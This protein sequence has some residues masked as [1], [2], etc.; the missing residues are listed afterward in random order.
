MIVDGEEREYQSG[1]LAAFL[2]PKELLPIIEERG[3]ACED[4]VV[5]CG[6]LPILSG[7]FLFGEGFHAELHDPILDRTIRLAYDVHLLK[8][9]EVI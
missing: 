6:T 1:K 2:S 5:F 8:D 7:E 4:M 9:A 3:Y